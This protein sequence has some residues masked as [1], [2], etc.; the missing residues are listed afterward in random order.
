MTEARHMRL[1]W[2][3][4]SLVLVL[5][6][7]LGIA[8]IRFAKGYR[9]FQPPAYEANAFVG[10]PEAGPSYQMLAVRDGFALGVDTAPTWQD[11]YIYFNAANCE[12]N[13]VRFLVQVY[14]GEELIAETGLLRPGQYVESVACEEELAPGDEILL[15]FVAYEGNG[16]HSEGVANIVCEVS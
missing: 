10:E 11:G 4:G 7:V 13:T 1:I 5:C 16:W 6:V 15:K 3:A 8:Y 9:T 14:Q 12:G 2:L